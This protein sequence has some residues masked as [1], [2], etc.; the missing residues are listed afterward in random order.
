MYMRALMENISSYMKL[1]TVLWETKP[2]A[3]SYKNEHTLASTT[4]TEGYS[5]RRF[6]SQ[7]SFISA[8]GIAAAELALAYSWE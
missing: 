2:A 5:E 3:L 8:V 1:H 4:I 6:N 7:F